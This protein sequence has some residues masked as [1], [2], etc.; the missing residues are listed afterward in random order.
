M[1]KL[2]FPLYRR[3][4]GNM[5]FAVGSEN[6]ALV[7]QIGSFSAHTYGGGLR[8]RLNT[9]Q[10]ISGYVARQDRSTSRT[11]TSFGVSYGFRF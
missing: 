3:L 6:F 9:K 5:F 2:G 8:C 1:A 10:D 7:D 4:S 11:Q